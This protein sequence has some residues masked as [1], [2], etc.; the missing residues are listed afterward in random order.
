MFPLVRKTSVEKKIPII[1]EHLTC[2]ENRIG[3]HFPSISIRNF[4]W[5]RN[6]FVN[7][8]ITNPLSFELREEEELA[9]ISSDHVLKL[10]HV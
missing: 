8:T 4:D 1:I 9:D 6:H 5:N 3:E 7:L 2:L 10:K